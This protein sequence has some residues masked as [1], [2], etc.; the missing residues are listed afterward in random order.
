M[1]KKL[2][3]LSLV[4]LFGF[5]TGVCLAKYSG[6]DGSPATPYRISNAYDMND[7]G[8]HEEDWGSHFVMVN[9]VNLAQFT[10][11]Q[12]NII[13]E[14]INWFPPDNKPFTGIFDGNGFTI[15]NFT[16]QTTDT[17][18]IGLF[19]CIDDPNAIIKD[20]AL[21]APN[22]DTGTGKYVGSL[23]GASTEGTIT[24]CHVVGAYISG[25]ESVGGLIGGMYHNFTQTIGTVSYCHVTGNIVGDF[26]VGGLIGSI[27]TPLPTMNSVT[28]CFAACSVV[29]DKYIGGLVGSNGLTN[30][31][32]GGLISNCFAT[33]DVDGNDS[34]G[35]L[36]GVNG[37]F[38]T[39]LD[40][41]ATGNVDGN[42]NTG[43]FVGHSGRPISFKMTISNCYSSGSVTGITDT[44]GFVGISSDT[45]YTK[46]FWD[47]DIN[48]DVNGIGNKTDPNVV[49]ETTANMQTESTFTS[50]GWDFV[51]ET[52]NGANDI[53]TIHNTVDY[54]IHV[55]PLINFVGWYEVDLADYAFFARCW[56]DNLLCSSADLI[57]NGFIDFED[58]AYLAN[59]WLLTGCGTCGGSDLT[60]DGD[61]NTPDLLKFTDCWLK[62][63]CQQADLDFSGSIDNKDLDIFTKYWLTGLQ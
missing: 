62:T 16:Y 37:H 12:F 44:G 13:G 26:S 27:A 34:T 8:L 40:C 45:Y 58:F 60:G 22:V 52:I 56:S 48:P 42:Y 21:I 51:G 17:N 36:V 59:Y 49:G 63:N 11:T 29:G 10:G 43:G 46:C 23:V 25:N 19:S 24:N 55:W 18:G 50:A 47:S 28:N 5:A 31:E 1:K 39:I 61:V 38:G 20:L 53:W 3:G 6:G 35:G 4:I 15:S 33:G 54:P 41:Y 57:N 2:L 14:W 30:N 9:D 32:P 7:I